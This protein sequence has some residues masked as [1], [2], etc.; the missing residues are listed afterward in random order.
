MIIDKNLYECVLI[1]PALSSSADRL[2]I[3]SGYATASMLSRHYENLVEQDIFARIDLIVGMTPTDGVDLAQHS[4]FKKIQSS[5]SAIKCR[6]LVGNNSVHAKV[7]V[8]IRKK[9][10]IVAFA[11]SANYTHSGFLRANRIETMSEIDAQSAYEFCKRVLPKSEMCLSNSIDER[12]V[13]HM[14]KGALAKSVKSQIGRESV[15]L[16]LVVK[17]KGS[18]H[19]KSGLNWGQRPNRKPNEAYIPIPSSIYNTDFFPP[20]K[21]RF[22]VQTDDGETLIF[23]RA[24]EKGKALHTPDDNSEIGCYFRRR[25]GVPNGSHVT[26]SHLTKYGRTDVTITKTDD[27]NYYLDFS[28]TD[29]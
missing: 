11:G 7:Y 21:D 28:V 10:P 27:E 4:A 2:V 12:V 3:V 24:Q 9:K 8:W 17:G 19:E 14:P 15:S 29:E 22:I 5:N 6:Y 25:L 20:I 23:T 18:T 16:S 1:E 26:R 13:L